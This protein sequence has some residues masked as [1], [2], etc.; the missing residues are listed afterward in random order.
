M[1]TRIVNSAVAATGTVTILDYTALSGLGSE[2]LVN[3]WPY[4]EGVTWNAATS[5]A[6]TATSLAAAITNDTADNLCTALAVGAVVTITANTVGAAGNSFPLALQDV[7]GA[8]TISGNT[9]SGGADTNGLLSAAPIRLK[10]VTVKST[11]T[12]IGVNV[13][14]GSTSSGTEYD[15]V[16]GTTTKTVVRN[17]KKGMTLPSGCYL[18]L[19]TDV[20]QVVAQFDYI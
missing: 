3:T 9:L 8:V 14:N 16:T 5:N 11:G 7:A 17:Y 2:V 10:S 20:T 15:L 4:V 13:R 18:T 12:N 1:A 6:A 19:G